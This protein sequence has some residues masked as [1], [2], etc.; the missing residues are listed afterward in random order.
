[1]KKLKLK[2]CCV[3]A[4]KGPETA[5]VEKI[6]FEEISTFDEFKIFEIKK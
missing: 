6:D 3:G 4:T 2:R 1:V 5:R